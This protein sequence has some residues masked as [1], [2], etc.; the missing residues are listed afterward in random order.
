MRRDETRRDEARR[1]DNNDDDKAMARVVEACLPACLP[2]DLPHLRPSPAPAASQSPR[3]VQPETWRL[4]TASNRF[5]AP[6][7]HFSEIAE[8][9]DEELQSP[10]AEEARGLTCFFL[11]FLWLLLCTP[12]LLASLVPAAGISRSREND[13][14]T[15]ETRGDRG[16][17]LSVFF[18][19]RT[20]SVFFPR[21]R[22]VSF[23]VFR[24]G[25]FCRPFVSL[26]HSPF[27]LFYLSLSCTRGK[28]RT[29]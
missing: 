3:D 22:Y 25:S 7:T 16:S 4:H 27:P 8:G 5:T 18:S 1:G 17:G 12:F 13:A 26:S 19:L 2:P 21:T 6:T 23:S 10:T 20:A 28:Q 14:I 9:D 11:F 15:G 29:S 24:S